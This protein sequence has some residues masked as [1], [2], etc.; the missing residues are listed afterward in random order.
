MKMASGWPQPSAPSGGCR[1][2]VLLLAL[3]FLAACTPPSP[4]DKEVRKDVKALK[5][6]MAAMQKQLT[7]LEAGQ[8]AIL[9]QLRKPAALPAPM[10]APMAQ[11]SQPPAA[12]EPLTV[13][14]LL[15][16]KDRYLGTQVRVR[17]QVGPV[18][19]HHKSLMLLS[20][21]G[22]VEVRF[23]NLPDQKMVQRLTSSTIDQPITVTGVVNLASGRG[24]SGQIQINAEAVEF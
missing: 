5:A 9:D 6:Q 11:P 8:K 2:L 23:G 16:N 13:S 12:S 10:P 24:A 7:Q 14:Q 4:K 19:V 3:I 15:T 1:L 18:M 22:M 20:P 21:Q 17:G